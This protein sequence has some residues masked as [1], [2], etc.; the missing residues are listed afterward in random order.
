M[1]V[2][3]EHDYQKLRKRYKGIACPDKPE[4]ERPDYPAIYLLQNKRINRL[5]F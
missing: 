3:K 5:F 4:Y 2:G 1:C